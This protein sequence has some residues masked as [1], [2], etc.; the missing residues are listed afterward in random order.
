MRPCSASFPSRSTTAREGGSAAR[1]ASRGRARWPAAAQWIDENAGWHDRFLLFVDE[2]DPHEPFDTPDA[3]ASLYDPDWEGPHLVHPPYMVGAIDR[4]DMTERQGRQVRACYGAKLT[5]IDHWFGRVLEALDRNG[6]ADTTAVIVCTDHGHYLG[7]RRLVGHDGAATDI[8]GKP[9][10]PV[11]EPM[12]HIPLMVR[13]PGVAA[14]DCDA[15]TTGVDLCATIADLFDVVLRQRT[16]GRSLMPLLR[17]ETTSI[18]DWALTGVWGREVH[19]V[20]RRRAK[21]RAGPVGDNAPLSMWSNRWSTMPM[22]ALSRRDELPTP[23]DRAV[24]A[25]MPGSD[26]PVIRQPFVVGDR[27]PYWAATRFTG[28]HLYDRGDDPDEEHNLAGTRRE[29]EMAELLRVALLEME[30]PPDQLLRLG[31]A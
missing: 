27:L 2:F 24:L 25:L 20:D 31:L 14:C 18:R 5:M 16:S 11:F 15:L 8:W 10:V 21:Y 1:T 4:G 28:N 19:V 6:L 30:A 12:G 29:A 13:M 3:Y 7:D 9:G 17:G 22:H 23:D 26:I